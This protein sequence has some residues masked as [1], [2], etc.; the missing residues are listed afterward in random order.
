MEPKMATGCEVNGDHC[1]WYVSPLQD[2]F[3]ETRGAMLLMFMRVS[4]FVMN[5]PNC[6]AVTCC[7]GGCDNVV[8]CGVLCA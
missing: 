3:T 7:G 6:G 2:W 8:T 4:W 5:V 1:R